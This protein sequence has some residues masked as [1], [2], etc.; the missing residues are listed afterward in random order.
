M[1][2]IV[3]F[4][5]RTGNTQFVAEEIAN[6]LSAELT[7]LRDKKNRNGLWGYLWAGFDALMQKKTQLIEQQIDLNLYDLIFIGC[8]NWA[9]N[10]PPVIRTFL[11]QKYWS[12]KKLVFFCTQDGL[13]AE[14][15]FNNLRGLTKGAEIISEKYFN[16]VNKNKEAVKLQIRD[17]LEKINK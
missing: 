12:D 16:Q 11:I 13:G 15:V 3:I 7:P 9:A 4:Y 17:W 6:R 1:K 8:P 2:S 14:R 5:S 10:L